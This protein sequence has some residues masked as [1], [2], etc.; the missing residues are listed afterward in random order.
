[1][2]SWSLASW[3]KISQN[4]LPSGKHTKSYWK[5]PFIVSF[6]I[7]KMWFAIV[8]LVYQRVIIVFPRTVG[9]IWSSMTDTDGWQ[10]HSW[11]G[12]SSTRNHVGQNLSIVPTQYILYII[13]IHIIY[14]L[15]ITGCRLSR[16]LK[17]KFM[18]HVIFDVYD[19]TLQ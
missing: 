7:K 3:I 6:P 8:M 10:W 19:V 1:V 16:C 4:H 12:R 14:I 11:I 2:R 17:S 9:I 18:N 5:W 15:Y 13:Y